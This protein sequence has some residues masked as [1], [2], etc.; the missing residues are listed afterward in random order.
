MR[1]RVVVLLDWVGNEWGCEEEES[2][3]CRGVAC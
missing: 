3:L 2:Q 1:C